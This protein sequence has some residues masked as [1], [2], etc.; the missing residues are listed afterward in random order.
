MVKRV[1]AALFLVLFL[2]TNT[3]CWP[4]V[5]G[6]ATIVGTA[7]YSEGELWQVYARNRETVR[8][9]VVDAAKDLAVTLEGAVDTVD[10]ITYEGTFRDGTPV[11]IDIRRL[12]PTK[13]EVGVRAGHVGV[14][15]RDRA[16]VFHRHVARNLS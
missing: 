6:T 11:T 13:I 10:V 1:L 12:A 9:A 5:V 14:W 7:V 4:V 2:V 3:G 8:K 16:E 15:D